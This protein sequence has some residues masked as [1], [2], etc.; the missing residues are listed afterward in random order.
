MP[1]KKPSTFKDLFIHLGLAI[2]LIVLIIC[3][4]FY[5]WL[6]IST[7][8]GETVTV[9]DLEGL[10]YDQLDEFLGKRSL[11]FEV[12]ADSGYFPG[13]APLAVLRQVPASN[14]KV[15]ENR[16][17]YVTLNTEK[18]P[19]V[20]FPDLIDKSLKAAQMV[21]KS[22]DLVLGKL[23]YIPDPVAFGTVHEA[24]IDGRIVLEGEKVEKGS[25]VE[26]IVGDGYGNTL[27]RSP[28]L[29][30]LD[31][32]EAITVIIGSGLKIGNVAYETKNKTFI[33]INDTTSI[34]ANTVVSS[35]AVQNQYP[36]P[37]LQVKIGDPIDLW[38]YKP[39]SLGNDGPTILD[40]Q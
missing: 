30:G 35:G 9:P 37:G 23:S 16:K 18:P 10:T 20:K 5:V 39:D 29:I 28:P 33:Q 32:E 22:Y 15:K 8:H 12:N 6:P 40:I 34:P 19:L 31:L 1:F 14:A 2:S 4:V 3:I 21:L 13:Y 11:R 26:L 38:V 7:H 17:I 27:F 24:R 25:T 36:K